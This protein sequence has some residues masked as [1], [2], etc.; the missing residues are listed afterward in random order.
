M[1]CNTTKLRLMKIVAYI[2]LHTPHP[3]RMQTEE[4]QFNFMPGFTK[5]DKFG[6]Q[7]RINTISKAK[8]LHFLHNLTEV[9]AVMVNLMFSPE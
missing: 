6:S 9:N 4:N 7:I 2:V 5:L 8:S 3:I 1:L